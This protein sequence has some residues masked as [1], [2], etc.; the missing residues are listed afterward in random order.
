M[1]KKTKKALLFFFTG[2]VLLTLLSRMVYQICVIK[3]Q[4]DTAIPGEIGQTMES[5]GQV[6]GKETSILVSAEGLLVAEVYTEPG[7]EVKKGEPL[8]RIDTKDMEDLIQKKTDEVESLKLQA[9]EARSRQEQSKEE[10]N[11]SVGQA[12]E[13]YQKAMETAETVLE[14]VRQ[15]MEFARQKKKDQETLLSQKR[16]EYQEALLAGDQEKA[17]GLQNQI[18]EIESQIEG[19][20][21]TI[22]EYD[23]AY[24]QAQIDQE[25][26]VRTARQEMEKQRVGIPEGTEVQQIQIQIDAGEMEI[27]KLQGYQK[28][29]EV[30]APYDAFVTEIFVTAGSRT[31]GTADMVLTD[32]RKGLEVSA[33]FTQDGKEELKEGLMVQVG[34]SGEKEEM[35]EAPIVSVARTGDEQENVEIKVD[36]PY[37]EGLAGKTA[38]II[39][40]TDTGYYPFVIDR[41]ALHLDGEEEYFI[42]VIK[43]EETVMGKETR[44][45]KKAVTVLDKNENVAAVEGI[46]KTEQV[47]ID[48]SRFV[49]E[50]DRVKIEEE[51]E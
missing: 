30:V 15:Q 29:P 20:A 39:F 43:E 42:Y 44:A 25:A 40:Q 1:K 17:S 46:G 34:L 8:Y 45:A 33:V 10:Q 26:S 22:L 47:I 21:D 9:E 36:L 51:L 38:E 48:S 23:A 4:V 7:E 13:N 50:N 32:V 3:V 31:A 16:N 11:L 24:S 37:Q 2:M 19:L 27:Q 28:T 49:Q 14:N 41:R 6:E 5:N 18:S 12:E 35:T